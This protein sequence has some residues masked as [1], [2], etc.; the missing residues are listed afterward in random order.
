MWPESWR[1]GNRKAGEIASIRTAS[2]KNVFVESHAHGGIHVEPG[3]GGNLAASLDASRGNDGMAS[4]SAKGG[5][6]VEVGA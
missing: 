6:V 4:H 2:M 3:Q 1:R 5:E